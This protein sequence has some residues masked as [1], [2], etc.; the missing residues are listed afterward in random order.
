MGGGGE[1]RSHDGSCLIHG[2]VQRGWMRWKSMSVHLRLHL[3][4]IKAKLLLL[5]AKNTLNLEVLG[6]SDDARFNISTF[7]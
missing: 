1:W 3:V 7:N 6:H 2:D 5:A 4:D